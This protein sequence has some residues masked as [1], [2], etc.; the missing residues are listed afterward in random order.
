MNKDD[1]FP[2]SISAI[3]KQYNGEHINIYVPM[4]DGL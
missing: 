2:L 1:A 3:Y 4:L